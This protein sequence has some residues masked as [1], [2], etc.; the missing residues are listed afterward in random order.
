MVENRID[1]EAMVE[2]AL[3]DVVRRSLRHAESMGLPGD[4]HFYIT[5]RTDFP[6]AAVPNRLRASYPT[7]MTVVLQHQFWG[8]EIDDNAFSVTLS[9]ANQLERLTVPF[10]AIT[11]FADPAVKFGLQFEGRDGGATRATVT[12]PAGKAATLMSRPT[13]DAGETPAAALPAPKEGSA[14]IV[15]LDAFRKK[16]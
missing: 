14:E 9:F 13:S 11:G 6:G 8:L 12:P 5:F 2:T 7:E 15:P 3:R 4:H 1:Y 16:S 10:A